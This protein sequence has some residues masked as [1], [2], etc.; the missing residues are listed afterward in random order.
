[1][2]RFNVQSHKFRQSIGLADYAKKKDY[3]VIIRHRKHTVKA[4]P[5]I[6]N[7]LK[8]RGYRFVTIPELL[9]I[10]VRSP[11]TTAAKHKLKL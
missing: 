9:Q 2:R 1:M 10:E 3:A 11:L 8:A 7:R 4:L 6:I 5:Q